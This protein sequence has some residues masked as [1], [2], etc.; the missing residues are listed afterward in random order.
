MTIDCENEWQSFLAEGEDYLLNNDKSNCK[1]DNQI[2]KC[3]DIYISTKTII[4]FL[5]S[6]IDINTIFWKIPVIK[7]GDPSC[8]VIKKQMK[9]S[10]TSQ[11]EIDDYSEKLKSENIVN[12]LIINQMNSSSKFK[13]V[14]KISIGLCK[15]DVMNNRCKKKSAFY[16]C[17]VLIFRIRYNGSFR[18]AHVKVFNTGKLEI[19]GVQAGNFLETVLDNLIDVL[20]NN[21]NLNLTHLNSKN[22]TVLINSNFNCGFYLNR[23]KFYDILKLKY[24]IHSSYD[25]C[26]YPGIMCKFYYNLDGDTNQ[27]GILKKGV[28]NFTVISFMIFRTGSILIVGKCEEYALREIYEYLKNI[29]TN[30]HDQIYQAHVSVEKK[31]VVKKVRK[32]TIIISQ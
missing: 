14:R 25:P 5:S 3:G 16:N 29:I 27:D 24:K 21:C 8:G 1:N 12:E 11:K 18:E 15:K 13:D 22:E 32:K 23:E 31:Q 30:E 7:Y 28:I 9:I 10:F 2:P 26:S 4:S 6:E 19:P 17:F 20:N